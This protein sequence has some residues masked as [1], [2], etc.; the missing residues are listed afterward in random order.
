M[1]TI[2]W[3]LPDEQ[4]ILANCQA[5]K[6]LKE[7]F[8]NAV[9]RKYLPKK[10]KIEE[11]GTS[12]EFKVQSREGNE[13]HEDSTEQAVTDSDTRPREEHGNKQA[14][15]STLIAADVPNLFSGLHFYLHRPN[16]LSK[17]KCLIPV[18]PDL[19]V[20]DLLRE[21]VLLEFP[22][23]FL[24]P[25]SPDRLREPYMIEAEYLKRY[26]EDAYAQVATFWEAAPVKKIT[27]PVPTNIDDR[28]VMEVLKK[29]LA[30]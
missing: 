4:K 2:E 10:R 24:R 3:I 5:T 23:V 17:I 21:R 20:A 22:T 28:K 8:T 13:H 25:E 15:E 30:S 12:T 27:E 29:D 1:W 26:G 19:T 18:I 14:G 9:G 6:T 7:A 11:A 16:A